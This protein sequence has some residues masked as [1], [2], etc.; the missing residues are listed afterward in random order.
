MK[1]KLLAV[2]LIFSFLF[3]IHRGMAQEFD[4]SHS[5]FAGVLDKFVE[6]QDFSSKVNYAELKQKSEILR[7][8]LAQ[9]SSVST[10]QYQKFSEEQKLAFLINA[11]NAFT[12]QLVIEHY[13]LKSI[14]DIGGVFRS[15]W[16]IKFFKLLERTR[17]LDQLEHEMIR[18][19]FD[20]PRIHFAI[21]CASIGCPGLAKEPYVA[22]TLN[23]QLDRAA[24]IFLK[25]RSRNRLDPENGRIYLSKIFDWFG[26]DFRKKGRSLESFLVKYFELDA[27]Q[28]SALLAGEFDLEFLDYDWR[29]NDLRR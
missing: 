8:Y 2:S 26:D 27:R 6:V 4:H 1:R 13:P 22:T 17:S 16:K 28:K 5:G 18:S 11:Y 19:S 9:L 12:L 23:Q 29:L 24:A 21:N 7:E 25:D 20:E 15:P 14:R 3:L 10:Q